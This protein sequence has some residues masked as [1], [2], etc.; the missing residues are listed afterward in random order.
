MQVVFS[1]LTSFNHKLNKSSLNGPKTQINHK[2]CSLLF[3]KLLKQERQKF[4]KI[5]SSSYCLRCQTIKTKF[6]SRQTAWWHH[7]LQRGGWLGL[8]RGSEG[9]RS[10]RQVNKQPVFTQRQSSCCTPAA[11]PVLF[12]QRWGWGWWRPWWWWWATKSLHCSPSKH[13]T[14]DRKL[15]GAEKEANKTQFKMAA[16]TEEP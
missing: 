7:Q 11:P 14:H 6:T 3:W 4:S 9:P 1:P 5:W 16:T 15:S 2:K 8:T 13:R 10:E 12:D